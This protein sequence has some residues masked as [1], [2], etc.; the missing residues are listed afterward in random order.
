MPLTKSGQQATMGAKKPGLMTII[1]GGMKILAGRVRRD[2][3]K[4]EQGK[5]LCTQM[6]ETC[7]GAY[8]SVINTTRIRDVHTMNSDRQ[9]ERCY[10]PSPAIW[11]S[12]FEITKHVLCQPLLSRPETSQIAFR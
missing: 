8:N 3:Q 5:N 1:K 6:S 11:C 12:I 2:T 4:D 7:L 9:P 10:K